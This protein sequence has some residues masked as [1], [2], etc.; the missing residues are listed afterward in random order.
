[1]L[2]QVADHLFPLAGEIIQA[3]SSYKTAKI[4]WLQSGGA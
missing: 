2:T 3:Y 4:G 1:M